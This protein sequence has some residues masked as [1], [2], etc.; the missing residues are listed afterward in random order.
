MGG[1]DHQ[2]DASYNC[3]N[4]EGE[5]CRLGAGGKAAKM[6]VGGARGS[7]DRRQVDSAYDGLEACRLSFGG[8]A[9]IAVGGQPGPVRGSYGYGKFEGF[10]KRP[11]GMG[12]VKGEIRGRDLDE[13]RLKQCSLSWECESW[14]EQ[15]G[16]V[17]K[18]V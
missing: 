14:Q 15:R 6:E 4:A 12:A 10:G 13:H 1:V 16:D 17:S 2:G 11:A 3:G 18:N 9:R 8:A 5:G 7:E